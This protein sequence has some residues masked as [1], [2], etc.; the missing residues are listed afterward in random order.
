MPGIV[1]GLSTNV[2]KHIGCHQTWKGTQPK[3]RL[4]PC[5]NNQPCNPFGTRDPSDA[6][7]TVENGCGNDFL[8]HIIRFHS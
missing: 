7:M 6:L 8:I 4:T 1:K 2:F 5:V 3:T